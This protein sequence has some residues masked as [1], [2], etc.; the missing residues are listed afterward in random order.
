MRLST[1]ARTCALHSNS[2][3]LLQLRAAIFECIALPA[4]PRRLVVCLTRHLA[5]VVH[6]D[7]HR[8]YQPRICVLSERLHSQRN[9]E[10]RGKPWCSTFGTLDQVHSG[11]V[12]TLHA[13]CILDIM[14]Y[15]C[16][17]ISS[18]CM[19][20]SPSTA[21]QF[22]PDTGAMMMVRAWLKVS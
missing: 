9:I 5:H 21:A 8:R 12:H 22:P 13:E 10:Q 15:S 18:L 14:R 4:E 3:A 20:L 2:E 1:R 11:A 16:R 7:I 6:H 17:K 19:P